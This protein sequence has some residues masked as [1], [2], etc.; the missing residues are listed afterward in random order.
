MTDARSTGRFVSPKLFS[1]PLPRASRSGRFLRRG[2]LGLIGLAGPTALVWLLAFSNVFTIKTVAIDGTVN[3]AVRS[4]LEQLMGTNLIL[5]S[6]SRLERSLPTG[7]SS[8]AL[9]R[10]VKGFPD[11]LRVNVSVRTPVIGWRSGDQLVLVDRDGVAFTLE[12]SPTES[13][14]SLPVITD[15]KVQPVTLGTVIVPRSF[16]RF[17][18]ELKPAIESRTGRTVQELSIDETTRA[19]D[20]RI[21]VPLTVRFSTSRSV[22]V[23]LDALSAVLDRYRDEIHESID[24]RADGR[25]FYR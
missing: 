3:A 11:T 6:T 24:L 22:T 9:L 23:Q 7:Q 12:E 14:A 15:R 13:A 19:V 17:I 21:D 5:L 16:V 1:T 10:L 4:S 20:V 18:A 8:L 25:V 2:L